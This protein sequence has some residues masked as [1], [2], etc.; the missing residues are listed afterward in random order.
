VDVLNR[1]RPR[2][3]DLSLDMK[4]GVGSSA[5]LYTKVIRQIKQ[6]NMVDHV[7][8]LDWDHKA[9]KQLKREF[10]EVAVR[11]LL[12]G[13][14]LNMTDLLQAIPAESVSM[15]YDLIYVEDVVKVQALGMAVALVEMWQPD[16]ERAVQLGVDIVSWGNPGEAKST[17]QAQS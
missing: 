10:P 12:H 9:L 8:I 6:T 13:R 1:A 7:L 16:F 4:G 14:S 17:L 11:A 15:S 3:V 2:E 5:R